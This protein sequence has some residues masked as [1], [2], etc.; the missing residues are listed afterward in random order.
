MGARKYYHKF[1]IDRGEWL[2]NEAQNFFG[3]DSGLLQINVDDEGIGGE[4]RYCCIGLFLRSLGVE[5]NALVNRNY[6]KQLFYDE[7]RKKEIGLSFPPDAGW[8]ICPSK[9][10]PCASN[11]ELLAA[12]NDGDMPLEKKEERIKAIF[13]EN[14]V[15]VT[16][17]GKL[18]RKK[19]T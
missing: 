5:D 8:L 19:A 15:K 10:E 12:V 16:F 2:P 6:S 17:R 18:F 3:C 7:D 14:G 1:T 4:D 9:A 11:E 13:A